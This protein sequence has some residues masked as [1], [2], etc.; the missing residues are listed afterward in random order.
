MTDE[1]CPAFVCSPLHTNI[2]VLGVNLKLMCEAWTEVPLQNL[3]WILRP[4]L[5]AYFYYFSSSLNTEVCSLKKRSK[6]HLEIVCSCYNCKGDISCAYAQLLVPITT[7]NGKIPSLP[8]PIS[9]ALIWPT[10]GQKVIFCLLI[11]K[12]FIAVSKYYFE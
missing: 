3:R 7:A 5:S 10:L 6:L 11:L 2:T 9:T 4:F 1:V 8:I 12:T